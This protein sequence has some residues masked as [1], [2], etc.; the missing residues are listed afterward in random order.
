MESKFIAT[1]IYDQKIIREAFASKPR[2][3]QWGHGFNSLKL[4]PTFNSAIKVEN[5][6]ETPNKSI[7]IR[8]K[9]CK[10]GGETFSFLSGEL[11]T[12]GAFLTS[13][14]S[15]LN[16]YFKISQI[17]DLSTVL[18]VKIDVMT[19]VSEIK[20]YTLTSN[21]NDLLKKGNFKDFSHFYGTHC[22]SRA[23]YGGNLYIAMEFS[24]STRK[25]K[26]TL[27]RQL[28]ELPEKYDNVSQLNAVLRRLH[29][30]TALQIN[31]F[32]VGS[33]TPPPKLDISGVIR[34]A[35][36]FM[37]SIEVQG[38]SKVHHIEYS[39]MFQIY[40]SSFGFRYYALP[41]QEEV[42]KI[43]HISATF[44]DVIS[45]TKSILELKARD[46]TFSFLSPSAAGKV[47]GIKDEASNLQNELQKRFTFRRESELKA[48]IT[49]FRDFP[50]SADDA[51]SR[52]LENEKYF[53]SSK[54]FYLRSRGLK[55]YV[56]ID[57]NHY[58]RLTET[59]PIGLKFTHV[60]ESSDNRA[61]YYR[62]YFFITSDTA[63][64][65]YL[66][67]GKN[68]WYVF[69]DHRL[70]VDISKCSWYLNPASSLV[71]VGV[72]VGFSDILLIY[73]RHWPGYVIGTTD[74]GQ[75]LLTAT[76]ESAERQARHQW[77]IEKTPF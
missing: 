4:Q 66:C 74:D 40:D 22:L 59:S 16:K 70:T 37:H 53:D 52:L 3:I 72:F 35:G 17:T 75:W 19:K 5:I 71:N 61:A 49:E 69:W 63:P 36:E 2:D 73:N 68:S 10:T 48:L 14:S 38:Y 51:L 8:L 18:V 12:A 25:E 7:Q 44:Q 76:K 24:S 43:V 29:Q 65:Y 13:T 62:Q 9:T 67:M 1:K 11:T 15:T 20:D 39:S 27:D 57:E 32:T 28:S 58:P 46:E 64:N 33:K 45:R 6:E 77:I 34:F 21:A 26:E 50:G 54:I 42:D 60:D 31:V 56:S 41:I 30:R 23:I 47:R 55:R